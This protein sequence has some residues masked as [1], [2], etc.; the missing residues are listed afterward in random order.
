MALT[1]MGIGLLSIV[2]ILIVKPLHTIVS[3]FLP[4]SPCITDL[5]QHCACHIVRDPASNFVMLAMVWPWVHMP[6]LK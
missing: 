1:H 4:R 6:G 5:L 3:T 2:C